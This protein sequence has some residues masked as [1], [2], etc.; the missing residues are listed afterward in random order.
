MST[1]SRLC[2]VARI[3][4]KNGSDDYPEMVGTITLILGKAFG[5]LEEVAFD[6]F[7]AGGGT[8]LSFFDAFPVGAGEDV[9]GRFEVCPVGAVARTGVLAGS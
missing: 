2:S 4:Q 8:T 7:G 9:R 6:A 3:D 1:F 5:G